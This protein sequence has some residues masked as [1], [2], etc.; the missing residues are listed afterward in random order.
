MIASFV[1]KDGLRE[2]P[3]LVETA[4]LCRLKACS[5]LQYKILAL[6]ASMRHLENKSPDER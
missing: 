1:I 6:E 4:L 2:V 5:I 3:C